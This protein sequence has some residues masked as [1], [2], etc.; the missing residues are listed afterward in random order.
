MNKKTTVILLRHGESLKNVYDLVGGK[1]DDLTR[2]GKQQIKNTA[3][4]IKTFFP[5]ESIVVYSSEKK[6]VEESAILLCNF[7][8]CPKMSI[9]GIKPIYL[10]V[11]DG[12]SNEDIK[13]K[14]P[15]EFELLCKW[16]NKEIEICDLRI[17]KMD[18][19]KCFYKS[20]LNV[21]KSLEL[22]KVNIIMCSNSLF[23]L[24]AN[25]MFGKGIGRGDG[26]KHLNIP[27]CGMLTFYSKNLK[28]FDLEYKFSDIN[29]IL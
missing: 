1:G 11:I 12:L 2:V 28:Q 3:C 13:K 15:E 27:N 7:L 18:S 25:I 21:L 20:G 29:I 24:F 19:Y 26:Y 23:I 16:R 6:H 8:N 9:A 5:K 22:Q 14:Y 4:K 17:P 10:G